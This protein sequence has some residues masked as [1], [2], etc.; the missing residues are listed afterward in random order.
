MCARTKKI[1]FNGEWLSIEDFLWKQYGFKI[2]LGLSPEAVKEK[3]EIID[4]MESAKM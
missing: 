2:S 3:W 4:E 1:Q